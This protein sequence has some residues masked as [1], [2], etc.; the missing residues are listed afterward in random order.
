MT[1]MLRDALGALTLPQIDALILAGAL[2]TPA[3][4]QL[5]DLYRDLGHD[6]LASL[7][8]VELERLVVARRITPNRARQARGIVVE[9]SNES[10]RHPILGRLRGRR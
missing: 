3:L 5:C 7:S 10:P 1:A 6:P 8:D 2:T 4:D 9:L